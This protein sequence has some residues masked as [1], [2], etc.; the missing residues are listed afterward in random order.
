MFTGR[1]SGW[2]TTRPQ[3]KLAR[4]ARAITA[5]AFT[6]CVRVLTPSLGCPDAI[7]AYGLLSRASPPHAPRHGAS[8]HAHYSASPNY[9]LLRAIAPRHVRPQIPLCC[10]RVGGRASQQLHANEQRPPF[11]KRTRELPL[12]FSALQLSLLPPSSLP[13]STLARMPVTASLCRKDTTESIHRRRVRAGRRCSGM[14]TE[15]L[16]LHEDAIVII[17]LHVPRARTLRAAFSSCSRLK[18]LIATNNFKAS[19]KDARKCFPAQDVSTIVRLL[20]RSIPLTP[21]ERDIVA[22]LIGELHFETIAAPDGSIS[23]RLPPFARCQ[24]PAFFYETQDADAPEEYYS[25]CSP[26]TVP[27]K[28]NWC[29]MVRISVGDSF[30]LASWTCTA[31]DTNESGEMDSTAQLHVF[32][33][34]GPFQSY[35]QDVCSILERDLGDG[36]DYID[37]EGALGV[38]SGIGRLRQVLGIGSSASQLPN[39]ILLTALLSSASAWLELGF[40]ADQ[41]DIRYPWDE[42]LQTRI[43]KLSAPLAKLERSGAASECRA[44]L[45][46]AFYL[47]PAQREAQFVSPGCFLL[48]WDPMEMTTDARSEMRRRITNGKMYWLE[49]DW[50]EEEEEPSTEEDEDYM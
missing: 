12:L 43:P 35:V 30:M 4:S 5:Q 47:P 46:V 17:L 1:G 10:V 23:K 33:N 21:G 49:N 14:P 38:V 18:S 26:G 28:R 41:T 2:V 31:Y 13:F 9:D 29:A 11:A 36:L 27:M 6:H 15:L 37:D 19:W 34:V 40:N 3:G 25:Y 44:R 48:G 45:G 39:A 22:E 50:P 32:R 16:N 7:A 8:A 20:A 24:P 42:A